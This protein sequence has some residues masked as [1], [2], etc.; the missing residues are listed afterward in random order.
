MAYTIAYA[1]GLAVSR[2]FAEEK[3][4]ALINDVAEQI[5]KKAPGCKK[6]GEFRTARNIG[7]KWTR[8]IASNYNHDSALCF[9]SQ[10]EKQYHERWYDTTEENLSD[11]WL[12]QQMGW[13]RDWVPANIWG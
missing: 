1:F 3:A 8:K 4:V 13:E 12:S 10:T 5:N 7:A 9:L 6:Y 2:K 11:A